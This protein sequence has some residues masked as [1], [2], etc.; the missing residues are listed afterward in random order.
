[1]RRGP[2]NVYNAGPTSLGQVYPALR[3]GRGARRTGA[4][5][6]SDAGSHTTNRGDLAWFCEGCS[7]GFKR[8]ATYE[9]HMKT[10]G[11]HSEAQFW[12]PV[13]WKGFTRK[14]AL[15]R[16]SRKCLRM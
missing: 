13:C 14:D 10:A 1:M 9:R 11:A 2:Y 4:M 5:S 12:C 6:G 8:K 3:L 7:R 15:M 16:H